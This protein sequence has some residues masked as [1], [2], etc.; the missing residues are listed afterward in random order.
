M[1]T[2]IE[3]ILRQMKISL[4]KFYFM[5]HIFGLFC[6]IQ[7]KANFRNLSRYSPF[8]EKTFSRNFRKSF[9]FRTFNQLLVQ[10]IPHFKHPLLIALDP[11]F[12]RKS[13]HFTYGLDSYYNGSASRAEKGLEISLVALI[14][15]DADTAYTLSVQQTPPS[16]ELARSPKTKCNESCKETRID[17]Y[18]K[19]LLSC[20]PFVPEERFKRK[21]TI[22]DGFFSKKKFVDGV[23]NAGLNMIS[24]L[25]MD[26]NLWT[27]YE[28][29]Q[30]GRGR[31]RVYGEKVKFEN[32]EDWNYECDVDV[33]FSA[34]WRVLY[35]KSLERKIKVVAL[36]WW[37]RSGKRHYVLLFSTDLEQEAWEI[38]AFYKGRFQM[39]F[40][41]RDAKQH[42]GLGDCQSRKKEALDFH[43][44]ASMSALN[45]AKLE[46]RLREPEE[47]PKSFSMAS[48]K[49]R[50]FNEHLM[51]KIFSKL[52]FDLTSIKNDPVF[53]EL[54]E[55]GSLAS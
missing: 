6:C 28:G 32:F 11:S 5:T 27:I 38:Y 44:N 54:S 55:Y 37:D 15:L 30:K 48:Y 46:E 3:N 18:L 7:G 29:E 34:Y 23:C 10:E 31:K 9:E 53:I 39:E 1:K 22:E 42:M 14:D 25:R 19:H 41:F 16:E 51:E 12:I 45:I 49:R 40:L 52:G 4:P 50:K 13:G 33:G 36:E 24:K 26:A 35:H 20:L 21:Y 17:F 2:I 8:C 47:V 43:F